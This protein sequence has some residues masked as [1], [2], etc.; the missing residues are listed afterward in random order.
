MAKSRINPDPVTHGMTTSGDV[1]DE[2]ES[3]TQ[4]IITSGLSLCPLKQGMTCGIEDKPRSSY[5]RNNHYCHV[6]NKLQVVSFKEWP[7]LEISKINT[8]STASESGHH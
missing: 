1:E 3:L 2:P 4:E 8:R 5:T 6:R 7:S